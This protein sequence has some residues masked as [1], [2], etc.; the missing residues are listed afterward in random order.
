MD[1]RIVG[2]GGTHSEDHD[3]AMIK[4]R[5]SLTPR[6]QRRYEASLKLLSAMVG[7]QPPEWATPTDAAEI[8]VE[9][10]DALLEELEK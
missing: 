1:E 6:E 5:R 8:A 7:L 9:W 3:R 4:D 2:P 10:A